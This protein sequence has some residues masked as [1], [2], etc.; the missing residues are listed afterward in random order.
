MI[1]SQ[2]IEASSFTQQ[3]VEFNIPQKLASSLKIAHLGVF[4]GA[5]GY[6]TNSLIGM[7]NVIKKIVLRDGATVLSQYDQNVRNYLE[8]KLLQQNNSRHRN[9]NKVLYASNFGMVSNN[10][11]LDS[12]ANI[13]G[14]SLSEQAVNPRVCTDKHDLKHSAV[15]EADS[16]L[17]IVNLADMLG[18]CGATFFDGDQGVAGV[19]PCHIF[20]NLK[21][22]IEFNTAASVATGATTIAQPYLIFDEL[23]NPALEQQ[24][25]KPSI[26]A[27]YVD[28]ELE[29]VFLGA[30]LSSKSFLNSFYGKTLGN[31]YMMYDNAAN[32]ALSPLQPNE[33]F[34]LNVNNTPL[35]QLTSGIDTPAKKSAFLRMLG[36][37][38]SIPLMS[39]RT[40]D[41]VETS[42]AN[43]NDASLYEG[44]TAN[45]AGGIQSQFYSG[46][47]CSYLA[48]PVNTRINQLQID[49]S[50]SAAGAV[51]VTMLFWGEVMK[52]LSKD[53][54]GSAMISYM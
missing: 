46:G 18:F 2:I 38:L 21:L 27:Q 34:R 52:I 29:K 17:A 41:G 53:K 26:Q 54:D 35:F 10:S 48:M 19:V 4:G 51:A 20:N 7:A 40:L 45:L 44:L 24:L 5:A 6:L 16:D 1:R 9:I 15:A 32:Y 3:R 30:S 36:I 37:D 49:Y 14:A 8:F 25:A 23:D 31:L 43:A 42:A 47:T 39:D 22:S 12:G 11:G 33:V 50:R 13:A 28:L